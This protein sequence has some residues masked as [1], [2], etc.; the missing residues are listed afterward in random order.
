MKKRI[1]ITALSV[2]LASSSIIPAYAALPEGAPAVDV[3][4]ATMD[5][6][7]NSAK[8]WASQYVEELKQIENPKD[9]YQLVVTRRG[10]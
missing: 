6:I 1:I 2:M 4:T 5:D 8:Q 10:R 3:E 7:R 9:R